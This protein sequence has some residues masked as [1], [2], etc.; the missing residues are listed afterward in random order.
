MYIEAVEALRK[1]KDRMKLSLPSKMV[2]K[3]VWVPVT[4]FSKVVI[5]NYTSDGL[6]S[7]NWSFSHPN[8][9]TLS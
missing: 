4:S 2:E 7:Q 1:R 3:L 6:L 8:C 5:P 9:S